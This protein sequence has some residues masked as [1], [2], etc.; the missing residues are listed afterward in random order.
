MSAEEPPKIQSIS[1]LETHANVDCT[2]VYNGV[3]TTFKLREWLLFCQS[4]KPLEQM[5]PD[6]IEQACN[7]IL[8]G[9]IP[10]F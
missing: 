1:L 2:L 3:E 8:A 6:K 7:D 5:D 4:D 10:S 9:R